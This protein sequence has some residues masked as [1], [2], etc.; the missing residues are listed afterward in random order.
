MSIAKSADG[1]VITYTVAGSGPLLMLVDGALWS[2]S[3]APARS[4]ADAVKTEFTAYTHDRRGRGES[5]DT[6]PY[7]RRAR[8]GRSGRTDQ[9]S[10]W[11]RPCVRAIIGRGTRPARGR[12][13]RADQQA[14]GVRDS[15]RPHGQRAL[16]IGGP[17]RRPH[18]G[19]GGNRRGDAVTMFWRNVEVP[20]FLV[21]IAPMLPALV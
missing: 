20:G 3:F 1:T 2:R 10:R 19:L 14:R 11:S 17:P 15:L 12:Q 9:G 16:R 8:S 13:R 6:A 4:F 21:T 18:Q 7:C 5:G